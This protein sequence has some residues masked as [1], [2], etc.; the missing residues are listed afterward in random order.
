MN[1]KQSPRSA[2]TRRTRLLVSGLALLVLTFSGV[3]QALAAERVAILP[4]RNYNGSLDYA[5][6]SY[7]LADSLHSMLQP[8]NESGKIQLVPIDSVEFALAGLNL[9]PS[10]PQYESDMWRAVEMLQ[11]D[12]VITGTYNVKYKKIFVN[13]Y[14]Y[15]VKTKIQNQEYQAKNV[16]KK[17]DEALETVAK[18]YKALA[19]FFEQ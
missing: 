10:N 12:K 13:A 3:A 14:I 16:Y 4:F 19:P 18:V 8:L 17:Y 1:M 5:A 11:A 7:T 9:D 2:S 6:P 15:D